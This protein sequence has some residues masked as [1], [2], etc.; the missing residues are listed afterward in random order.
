MAFPLKLGGLKTAKYVKHPGLSRVVQVVA[1]TGNDLLFGQLYQER[2][3]MYEEIWKK[4][5]SFCQW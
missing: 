5:V 4:T 1:V 3:L 2:K